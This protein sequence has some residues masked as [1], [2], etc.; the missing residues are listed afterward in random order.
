LPVP[1][2]PSG[3]LRLSGAG[4]GGVVRMRR[5]KITTA[6]SPSV[7][8]L[9]DYLVRHAVLTPEQ[10]R[11]TLQAQKQDA[12]RKL[13]GPMLI[14]RQLAS[15]ADVRTALVAQVQDAVRERK[16]WC[17]GHFAFEPE[18]AGD[19]SLSEIDLELDPQAVL[20]TIFKEEDEQQQAA[21]GEL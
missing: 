20:L 2:R 15:A 6:S 16:D 12:G 8:R 19:P 14:D 17:T 11:A 13:I 10:L 3:R 1:P 21:R 9:G 18:R 5:G 4:G 7:P